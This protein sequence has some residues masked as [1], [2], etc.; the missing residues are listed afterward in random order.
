NGAGKSTAINLW[1]GLIEAD[2]GQVT[3]LG[4]APQASDR[5]QGLGAMMQDVELPKAL[6]P[7]ELVR[8][9]CSYY[10]QPLA[11]EEV[12]R[13]AGIGAFADRAYGKLSSG[14]RR[15]TQFAV[16]ICGNPRVLL[17]DEP[18]VGLVVQARHALWS[19]IRQ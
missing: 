10:A 12:L 4:G 17:L 2:A 13:R 18:S 15:L 7:R 6:S 1:L 19:N 11:L 8:L 3:L 14:Q 9:A 5:R 16:A